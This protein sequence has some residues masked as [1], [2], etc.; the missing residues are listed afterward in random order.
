MGLEKSFLLP[1]KEPGIRAQLV[2]SR[3]AEL[4]NDF[5]IESGA[6]STHVLNAVS[7]SFTSLAPFAGYVV[8][9]LKVES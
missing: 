2:D 4:L 6:Y 8:D 7:P 5:V 3:T 9:G 1:G